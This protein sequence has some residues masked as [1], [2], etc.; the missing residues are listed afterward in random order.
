MPPRVPRF[1]PHARGLIGRV[2]SIDRSTLTTPFGVCLLPDA[3][4]RNVRRHSTSRSV[5]VRR[6]FRLWEKVGDKRSSTRWSSPP[7]GDYPHMTTIFDF[8]LVERTLP[9]RSKRA[10]RQSLPHG[11]EGLP[12]RPRT[13]GFTKSTTNEKPKSKRHR[14]LSF[15]KY[16]TR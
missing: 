1:L 16:R 15:G 2:R 4:V 8:L 13:T 3:I 14:G 10:F 11:T 12:K 9:A 7:H 5:W 6:N